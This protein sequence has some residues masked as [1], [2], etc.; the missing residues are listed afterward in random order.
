VKGSREGVHEHIFILSIYIVGSSEKYVQQSAGV[1][2]IVGIYEVFD[3]LT[4]EW[5]AEKIMIVYS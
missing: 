5:V 1:F 3:I 4:R 2:F